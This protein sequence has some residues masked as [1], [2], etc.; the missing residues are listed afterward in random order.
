MARIRALAQTLIEAHDIVITT[1]QNPDG[2]GVGSGLALARALHRLG[3]RVRFLCPTPVARLWAFM[4]GF[5][6]IRVVADEA[7]AR[8]E[9]R[10]DV[11]VSVDCGDLE[12]LGA[13]VHLRRDHLMNID[14]HAS[15][16]RFGDSN[17]VRTDDACTGMGALSV[18]NGMRVA[19]DQE[20][21]ACLYAAVCFYTGRFMHSNTTARVLRWS[22]RLLDTGIDA[23]AINR[24]MT[25]VRSTHD[26]AIQRLG[27][28]HLQVDEQE[29]RLAG[30]ALSAAA[31]AA[32]G[33]P[34]DWGE[35]V[36]IPRS[37]HGNQI[38]FLAREAEDH[39][40][41]RVSLRANPPYMV[42]AVAAH[43]GGGGHFQAAGCT[44]ERDL[45]GALAEL[46]PRLR[47][48]LAQ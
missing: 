10:C 41:V 14:H 4:P 38:A 31:I 28:E 33:K 12:R 2:D 26:L 45:T 22:A 6:S 32:V 40:S 13:L 25:Y 29:P 44:I 18:I 46:L 36:E 34:D 27:I 23:A 16:D 15:N 9:E 8:A 35:L 17:L 37:L 48:Q 21:A 42:S 1:H 3:K 30:I 47:E 19:L 7:A 43:F 11:L 5:E 39:A 24:A 20:M